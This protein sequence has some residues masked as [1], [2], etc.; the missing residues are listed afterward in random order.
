LGI[1]TGI[2]KQKRQKNRYSIYIDNEYAFSLYDNILLKYGLKVGLKVD[3]EWLKKLI[4]EDDMNRAYNLSLNYLGYRSRSK[5]EIMIY[6]QGKGSN[7]K[8]IDSVIEKLY[9]YGFIDD[10]KF[11]LSWVQNRMKGKPMGRRLIEHEL[12]NKGI[13]EDIIQKASNTI[14]SDDEHKQ[15]SILAAKYYEKYSDNDERKRIGKVAQALRR[16]GFEWETINK[17]M[18]TFDMERK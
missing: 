1:I 9:T 3:V 10:M 17:A 2:E 16:R 11:A 6:L 12:R 15:A 14:T 7:D 4:I 18:K 8:V 5:K 13:E